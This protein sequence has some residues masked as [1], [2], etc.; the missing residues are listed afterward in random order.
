MAGREGEE[1]VQQADAGVA[2]EAAVVSRP[3]STAQLLQSPLLGGTAAPVGQGAQKCLRREAG[4]ELLCGR[5]SSEFQASQ[6]HSETW[7][8]TN[9]QTTKR[10]KKW[11]RGRA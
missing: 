9:G 11:K 8:Q 7:P 4:Y 6:L 1:Q 3:L 5:V 2:D 10:S